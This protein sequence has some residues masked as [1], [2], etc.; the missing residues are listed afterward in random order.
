MDTSQRT[1]LVD[2]LRKLPGE[3][4]QREI[5]LQR[6]ADAYAAGE[7]GPDTLPANS[8]SVTGVTAASRIALS[9]IGFTSVCSMRPIVQPLSS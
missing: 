3:G 4:A 6:L 1:T 5:A 9:S 8:T 7:A 2:Q